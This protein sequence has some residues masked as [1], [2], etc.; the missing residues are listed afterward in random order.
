M[1]ARP[2]P[3][4]PPARVV[5]VVESV[6]ARLQKLNQRLLPAPISLLEM[7]TAGWMTQAIYAATKLGIADELSQGPLS[8]EEIAKR[9]GAHPEAT[10]RLLRLLASHSIF[11]EQ[12]DGRYAL[13]PM[14]DALRTDSPTSMRGFALFVGNPEHWSLLTN[15]VT[16]G[17]VSVPLLR[18][19]SFFDY[20]QT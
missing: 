11:S 17:E 14:A 13:T 6:R 8:P 18:G 19:M 2:A 4:V 3:R 7:V 1:S 5:R 9:V 20:L 10:R 12:A 15:S 16:T